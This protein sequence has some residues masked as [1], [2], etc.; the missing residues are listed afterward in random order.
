M[1]TS[2]NVNGKLNKS[3]GWEKKLYLRKHKYD[4]FIGNAMHEFHK[5][6]AEN[7]RNRNILYQMS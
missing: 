2:I 5:I 6:M 4:S 7:K 3:I 1:K